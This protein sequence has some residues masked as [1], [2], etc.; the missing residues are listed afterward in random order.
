MDS[1][2]LETL[3]QAVAWQAAGLPVTL[4]TVVRTW[5]SSPRP[6]GA[7]LAI[8]GDGRLAGSVSGGCIEDDLA[9]RLRTQR[10]ERPEL[11]TYGI[12]ADQT[13]RFQLPCGGSLSLVLEPLHAGSRLTEAL[14]RIERGGTQRWLAIDG[15]Q[16]EQV[17]PLLKAFWQDNGFVI[18]S[19]EPDIGLMETDWAEN[20][21][22]LGMDPVR[23]LLEGV[24]LGG[25]MSTPER[26]KFRVRL[27]RTANGTEVYFTHRGMYE[28]YV[29]EGKSETKW[30]PRPADPEL[31]TEFLARFMVR[32]GSSEA[33]A[34]ASAKAAQTQ[35]PAVQR[36][37]VEGNQVVV[38]DDFDRAWRRVGLA[39]DRVGLLVTDRDR[40]QGIYYVKPAKTDAQNK[41]DDSGFWQSLAF[42]RDGKSAAPQQDEQYRIVLKSDAKRTDIAFLDKAGQPLPAKMA[43]QFARKLEE[44][45]R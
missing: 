32:L 1:V 5:G 35:A 27:E 25:V 18:K 40:S 24:G 13:R 19:E 45:L 14:A 31:E 41:S 39:L 23:R 28:T 6:E 12:T 11:V 21:A 8:C 4:A 2:N 16:P 42:W 26:D 7:L 44:Q 36:A 9:D 10:L 22:K 43:E 34:Q 37:R 38:D 17:W 30:Q 29:N 33:Q 3:R 15:K 20:R